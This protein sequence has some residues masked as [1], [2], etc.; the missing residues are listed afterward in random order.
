MNYRTDVKSGPLQYTPVG[1]VASPKAK[2]FIF[3][4][5]PV[6]FKIMPAGGWQ[7]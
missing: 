2:R 5:G 6:S 7:G 3:D 4:T 1:V